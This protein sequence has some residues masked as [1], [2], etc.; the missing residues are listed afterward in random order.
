M[1]AAIAEFPLD[2]TS[3]PLRTTEA[4]G[5]R[6]A[7]HWLT[8]RRLHPERA[9][10]PDADP[11]HP[12]LGVTAAISL[13]PIGE[14]LWLLA[15]GL[16]TTAVLVWLGVALVGRRLVSRAL[17]PIR[18]LADLATGMDAGKLAERLAPAPTGDE[19]ESLAHAMNG[20]LDRLRLSFERQRRFTG[21]AAHQ[22]RTPLTAIIGQSEIALRR[23]RSPTEYQA[24]LG[25][26][27]RQALHLHDLV[28]S[29]LFLSRADGEAQL[30]ALRVVNLSSWLEEYLTD[31]QERHAQC[32]VAAR[33]APASCPVYVQGVLLA[34]LVGILL[35]NAEK[36]RDAATPI[37]V[38]LS[39]TGSAARLTIENV[40]PQI[41]SEELAELFT[42][43]CRGEQARLRG[44]EGAGLGLSIARR[45][46]ETF[47]GTLT[48]DAGASGHIRF[49][50][51]LPLAADPEPA[52]ARREPQGAEF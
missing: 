5:W 46:A 29:L 19:L 1:C 52:V 40:G 42:P 44:V 23:D 21:D 2:V 24:V 37:T 25:K 20:M 28:E 8:P 4:D 47:K 7:Q 50:I 36:Y 22:L 9:Y 3:T 35:D 6:I 43:F 38:I 41:T 14:L 13:E 39:A 33:I 45:L 34:E 10:H 15:L 11:K 51:E 12:A 31:W 26:L 32:E 27:H 18:R 49:T 30:R 16:A 48:A 17:S